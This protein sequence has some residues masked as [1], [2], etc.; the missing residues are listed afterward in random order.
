MLLS[1][2]SLSLGVNKFALKSKITWNRKSHLLSM[3]IARPTS[4]RLAK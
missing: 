2:A 3:W 4:F 1:L